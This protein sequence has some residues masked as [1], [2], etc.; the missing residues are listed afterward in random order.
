MQVVLN[1][2]LRLKVRK[3]AHPL[4]V[5]KRPKKDERQRRTLKVRRA[6]VNVRVRRLKKQPLLPPRKV[7]WVVAPRQLLLLK[8]QQVALLC[9][10]QPLKRQ[11]LKRVLPPQRRNLRVNQ[12]V[13]ELNLPKKPDQLVK[14]V[15]VVPK[16]AV[17]V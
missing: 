9:Q 15:K 8:Q 13:V 4:K 5:E 1:L 6:P 3:R 2:Q 7:A 10:H 14:V 17:L 11:L 16:R 12:Q